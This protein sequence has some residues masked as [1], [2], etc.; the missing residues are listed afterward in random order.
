[1]VGPPITTNKRFVDGGY[2]L[3][4]L[5]CPQKI[6]PPLPYL[7]DAPAPHG[8]VDPV[9]GGRGHKK[10]GPKQNGL[11]P[12]PCSSLPASYPAARSRLTRRRRFARTMTT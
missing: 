6:N 2:R 1:M 8:T 12:T 3:E 5:S 11:L 9:R 4:A 10:P 7:R